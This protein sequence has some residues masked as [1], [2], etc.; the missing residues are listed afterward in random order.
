MV[1]KAVEFI[2]T[3]KFSY[4]KSDGTKVEWQ[5]ENENAATS[6]EQAVGMIQR[7]IDFWVPYI[8]G[9]LHRQ[10]K[11]SIQNAKVMADQSVRKNITLTLSQTFPRRWGITLQDLT[12]PT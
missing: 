5:Q 3:H 11:I 4:L 7:A 9:Q 8:A 2:A 1:S 12:F 10:K 6:K